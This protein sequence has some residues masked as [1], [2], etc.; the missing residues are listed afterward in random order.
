M[1]GPSASV[2]LRE[3]LS[4][5]QIG[6][7][8]ETIRA[9]SSHIVPGNGYHCDFWVSDLRPLGGSYVGAGKP[10][11]LSFY[12]PDGPME[13]IV[14]WDSARMPV[15]VAEFGFVPQQEVSLAAF[16]NDRE[17]HAILGRLTLYV[18][19]LIGGLVDFNGAILPHLPVRITGESFWF[20]KAVWADVEP[21]FNAMAGEMPGRIVS[22]PYETARGTTWA[23]HV[24]DAA[25]LRA[26]LAHPDFHMIK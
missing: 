7:I 24:A 8:N 1:G 18:A 5:S 26:W 6:Q 21:Y 15:F 22:F 16:C 13:T 14:Q 2:L 20:E 25:F 4:A 9:I 17:D 12:G 19:E 23:S 10:L 3:P 11:G